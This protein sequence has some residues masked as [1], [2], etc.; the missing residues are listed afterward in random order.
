MRRRKRQNGASL[1]S[2][3]DTMTNVVGILVILL[4]VTQLGVRDAV[5]RIADSDRIDPARIE[6]SKE[7]Y[8][9]L[10]AERLRLTEKANELR[11]AADAD[12]DEELRRLAFLIEGL[13][14]DVENLQEAAEEERLAKEKEFEQLRK[15]AL[16]E[17][18]RQRKELEPLER[19]HAEQATELERLKAL[20]ATIDDQAP[21]AA[22]VITLPNPRPAPE[23]MEKVVFLCREGRVW[24]IDTRMLQS[25]SVR[26]VA[27]IIQRRGLGKNEKQGVDPDVLLAEFNKAKPS[28]QNFEAELFASGRVPKLRLHRVEGS[29]ETPQELKRSNSGYRRQLAYI[30]PRGV[31]VRFIVWPDGFDAYLAARGITDKDPRGVL[32]GWELR[33]STDEYSENLAGDLRLGPPPPPKPPGQKPPATPPKPPARKPLPADVID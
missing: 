26:Q 27:G 33:T 13:Q 2:L 19:T 18:D 25:A 32:A 22:K 23:G 9:A 30:N 20:L 6:T 14:H 3:L 5:E 21:V 17:L 16:A 24:P 29:G 12:A 7:E 15:Q 11:K 8:L 1:D 31:Y 28:D 4:T 10:Q